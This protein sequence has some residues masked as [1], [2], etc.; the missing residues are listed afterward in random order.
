MHIA[1]PLPPLPNVQV[2]AS[3]QRFSVAATAFT[4]ELSIPLSVELYEVIDQL[5]AEADKDKITVKDI[6]QSVV[7]HFNL[8][9]EVAKSM[10]KLIKTR[11]MDL[12]DLMDLMEQSTVVNGFNK[13]S[14]PLTEG[15]GLATD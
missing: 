9:K 7:N 12:M 5:F 3:D 14:I 4:S 6:V 1:P 15:G 10:K 2:A 8:S 13:N 11:L